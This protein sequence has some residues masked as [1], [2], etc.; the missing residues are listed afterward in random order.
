MSKGSQPVA[1]LVCEL[2]LFLGGLV[3]GIMWTTITASYQQDAYFENSDSSVNGDVF[4]K[5]ADVIY[6]WSTV[7]FLTTY[8]T[9]SLACTR[10]QIG[11]G[12]RDTLLTDKPSLR[13][14]QF[15]I[16]VLSCIEVDAEKK[17]WQKRVDHIFEIMEE[18]G[19]K[20]ED[21]LAALTQAELDRT[22]P[23]WPVEMPAL[24]PNPVEMYVD[25]RP[26]EM[27]GDLGAREMFVPGEDTNGKQKTM[28]RR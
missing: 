4:N 22:V 26:S 8:V 9:I 20:P 3:I 21:I 17:S 16:F 19:Q 10:D 2:L 11:P 15:V 7:V 13:I 23:T 25:E 1:H 24:N 18:R 28:L 12:A 6:F 14:C 27:V 5:W